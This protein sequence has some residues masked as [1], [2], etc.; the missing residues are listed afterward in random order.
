MASCFPLL[1]RRAHLF[2]LSLLALSTHTPKVQLLASD[3]LVRTITNDITSASANSLCTIITCTIWITLSFVFCHIVCNLCI[4]TPVFMFP[5][6]RRT[7][8]KRCFPGFLPS[9]LTRTN[10]KPQMGY[11]MRGGGGGGGI[12]RN[13]HVSQKKVRKMNGRKER[14]PEREGRE[15]K[16]KP[17][18]VV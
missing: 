12:Y 14:G 18:L 11:L 4:F 17:A 13:M 7:Q 2:D 10:G 3:I 15:G 8:S 6:D 9:S 1:Y 5:L 16:V